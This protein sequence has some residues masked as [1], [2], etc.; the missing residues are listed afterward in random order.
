MPRALLQDNILKTSRCSELEAT[1]DRLAKDLKQRELGVST[2]QEQ[3]TT[4]KAG[5]RSSPQLRVSYI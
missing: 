3:I 1:N 2:L 5:A 4:L